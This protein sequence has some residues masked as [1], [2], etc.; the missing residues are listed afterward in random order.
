MQM[1]IAM[2]S[3]QLSS[4]I[5]SSVSIV[6]AVFIMFFIKVRLFYF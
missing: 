6:S 4:G 5:G 2:L 1:M 3:M